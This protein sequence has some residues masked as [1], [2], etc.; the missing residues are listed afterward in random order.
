[1]KKRRIVK[2]RRGTGAPPSTPTA[3]PQKAANPANP[4]AG[5]SLFGGAN[6]PEQANPPSTAAQV[7]DAAEKN[8]N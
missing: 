2:A 4:F 1:M 3:G 7:F 5:I 8:L 6:T